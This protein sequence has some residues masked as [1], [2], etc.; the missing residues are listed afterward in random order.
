MLRNVKTNP[1]FRGAFYHVCKARLGAGKNMSEIFQNISDI[2]R[3]ISEII[4]PTCG[5]RFFVQRKEAEK[6]MS[7]FTEINISR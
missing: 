4:F 2:F 7:V 6:S 3:I 1:L 5:K